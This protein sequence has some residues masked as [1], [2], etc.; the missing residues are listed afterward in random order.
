MIFQDN[1]SVRRVYWPSQESTSDFNPTSLN[2]AGSFDLATE[3]VLICGKPT[4][5][6]TLLWTNVDLWAMRYIGGDLIYSFE[7]VG[8]NCGIV[9]PHAAVVLDSGAYWISTENKFFCFDGR[10]RVLPC[11]VQDYV[12][13]NFSSAYAYKVWAL[14]NPQ[15]S[16]IT[17]FY[18]SAGASECDSYVTYNYE[19]NHWVFGSLSRVTGVTR[20]SGATFPV[21][22]MIDSS[23]NIYDHE[24]GTTH[25]TDTPYLE[26]G[27]FLIGDGDNVMRIQRIV[28][29]DETLGD[30]T[31]SLYTSM[32]P[33]DAETLNGPYTLGAPTS[34]R[35]TARQARLKL[36]QVNA[37]AW[38]VGILRLGALP[39]GRR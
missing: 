33:D 6:E 12:F 19:E 20:R 7:Q 11:E 15:F 34:V 16:E 21:P 25:G 10:V 2:T 26:S 29:D 32:F 4:K 18:P 23:G 13:N 28:P 27:P 31:A 22:V 37:N 39:A 35:V 38:R 17:W 9:G 8:K 3:G 1:Y 24:T 30:V 5:G 36:T 14:A